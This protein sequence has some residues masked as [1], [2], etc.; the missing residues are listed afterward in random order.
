MKKIIF[1]FV[2]NYFVLQVSAQNK[3]INVDSL[4]RQL[5][6]HKNDTAEVSALSSLADYY[7]FIQF[8]SSLYYARQT[9]DL[10]NKINDQYGKYLGLR[11]LFFALNCQGNYPKALETTLDMLRVATQIQNDTNVTMGPHYFLGV[12]NR[13]MKN[14]PNAIY[15]FNQAIHL[16][17]AAKQPMSEMFFAYS[18]L[19][20]IYQA[21]K[22]PDS[23]LWYAQKGYDLGLQSKI[24]EK[25]F[26]L[27]IA[28]LGSVHQKMGNYDLAK[29]Y[30]LSGIQQSKSFN[31]VYFETRNY[32]LLASL[33]SKTG[34]QD[35]C[36]HYA[37]ISLGLCEQHNF[38]EF[39][40]DA[41]SL[42]T[43][44]YD[45]Q[46][47]PD[48]TLKYMRIMI[49]AKDS[50]FSESKIQ[51]FQE[52]VFDEKQHEQ[53]INA[54]NER[55]RNQVK[56]Y[57]LLIALAVLL[58]VGFILYRN[59]KQ[60]QKANKK[61]EKAY[62]ELKSTQAQLIQSEKMAS[63]GELTAGIAHEI[64]NPLNFVNNF[65]DVN[66]ELVDELQSELRAGNVD[67]AIA[68]S[69]DIRD[70]EEK[71]NHH[72]K[73][74]DGI[75]KGM[76]QHSRSST[77]Q[78]ERTDINALADEYLRL[79]YHGLKAKDKD[80]NVDYKTNFDKSIDKINIVP[81][82]IGRVLLNLY[83]NAFYAVNEK[84]KLN[85]EGYEPTVSVATKKM[86]NVV[87]LTVTDNGNGIPQNIVDKIFQPFFTTKP[88]GQG[89]GLGLSLSYDI[90]KAHGGEIKVETKEG[91]GSVFTIQ[92]PS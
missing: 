35:S 74:A 50:V 19:A 32:N 12:L 68:I 72:G 53:E 80:F 85:I 65:S 81:Q 20:I 36:I 23:A 76:L 77:G 3:F 21:E 9:I 16:E 31:N 48:S 41:A 49:T 64:Q 61:I 75:V 79:S 45:F 33:F 90:I 70:N 55:Y 15:E 73:R 2:L 43:Q 5:S 44:A 8:D 37:G 91:E 57:S 82:D 51:Q 89:T 4:K 24:F 59:N 60:K 46:Q 40:F 28:V 39:K 6:L 18:N 71:I 69:N 11:S 66:K 54:A 34:H 42:L 38:S 30:F 52:V 83:N 47:K 56:L 22:K 58:A 17:E 63:L 86:G 62:G 25:Y 14:F 84:K 7:G 13:E 29:N 87:L 78:K 88:T 27:A 92:L 10:S 1:L 67:D 26:S